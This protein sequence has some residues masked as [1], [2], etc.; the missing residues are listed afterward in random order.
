MTKKKRKQRV[1]IDGEFFRLK[2]NGKPGVKLEYND[3]WWTKSDFF[4]M[5]SSAIKDLTIYWKPKQR[6]LKEHLKIKDKQVVGLCNFCGLYTIKERLQVDHVVPCGSLS[7]LSDLPGVIER[8]FL[9]GQEGWQLLCKPCHDIKT[10]S[11]RYNVTLEEAAKRKSDIAK[12]KGL[13]NMVNAAKG[14]KIGK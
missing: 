9:H 8:T 5:L 2:S 4:S 12:T 6:F 13:R 1:E 3:N 10:Y 14:A 11:E 7:S